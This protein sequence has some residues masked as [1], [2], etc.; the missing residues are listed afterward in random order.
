MRPPDYTPWRHAAL[1]PA[2]PSAGQVVQ[3]AICRPGLDEAEWIPV[4]EGVASYESKRRWI[5]GDKDSPFAR[6]QNDRI[7]HVTSRLNTAPKK[8][9]LSIRRSSLR[10]CPRCCL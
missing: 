5:A 10:R 4:G 9:S 1:L 8:I 7:D 6:L 2:E 3:V